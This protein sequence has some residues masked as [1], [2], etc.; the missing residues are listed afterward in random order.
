MF[1]LKKSSKILKIINNKYFDK[2][3]SKIGIKS[4]FLTI[5]PYQHKKNILYLIIKF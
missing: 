1:F 4:M 2:L 3:N 5:F